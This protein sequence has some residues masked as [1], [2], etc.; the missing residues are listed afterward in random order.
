VA[1]PDRIILTC[2]HGGNRIPALYTRLF[3]TPTARR[4]LQSH[5]GYDLGALP[6]A[7]AIARALHAPLRFSTVSRLLVELNRSIHHPALFSAFVRPLSRQE[8]QTIVERHYLPFR[9]PVEQDIRRAINAGLTVLHLS[10]HSFTPILR[11]R[12]RRADIG[13]LYDPRRRTEAELCR[14]WQRILRGRSPAITVRRN[15]PYRGDADGHTTAL[16]RVFPAARYL[17][18][19][20]EVNNKHLLD[21]GPALR[22]IPTLLARTLRQL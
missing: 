13:L 4:A 1:P 16:R 20:V 17:G 22:M 5:R 7:R 15:Y 10:I 19:E 6:L 14:R 18:V 8:R 3:D 11:A 9:V 21:N 12:V 2:E